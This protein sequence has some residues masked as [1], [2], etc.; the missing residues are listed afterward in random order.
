MHIKYILLL[1]LCIFKDAYLLASQNS[2]DPAPKSQTVTLTSLPDE[3]N[4]TSLSFLSNSDLCS[5][6]Q[7]NKQMNKIAKDKTL[8]KTRLV[9]ISPQNITEMANNPY[10]MTN[11][12]V[13]GYG[14]KGQVSCEPMFNFLSSKRSQI[15]GLDFSNARLLKEN[16]DTLVTILSDTTSITHLNMNNNMITD[17]RAKILA[18]A[19]KNKPLT[20]LSLNNCGMEN[21][22]SI[23]APEFPN[24]LITL[25]LNRNNINVQSADELAKVLR[26]NPNLTSLSLNDCKSGNVINLI[27]PA[28]PS[29]LV[30]L[31]FED[32]II[33]KEGSYLFVDALKRM[34][35]L[36]TLSLNDSEC[37]GTISLIAPELPTTLQTLNLNKC[38]L[39]KNDSLALVSAFGTMTKLSSLSLNGCD[40]NKTIK[41]IAPNLPDTLTSLSLNKNKISKENNYEL[42]K[43]LKTLVKLKKLDIAGNEMSVISLRN[44]KVAICQSYENLEYIGIDLTQA[45]EILQEDFSNSILRKFPMCEISL[46]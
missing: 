36:T 33:D 39:S 17:D 18:A 10:P 46:Y 41:Y 24:T 15:V 32:N 26:R 7:A 43:K 4:L 13:K 34:R 11:I 12:K 37:V 29:G 38:Q 14:L 27:I 28:L 9:E 25:N 21:G 1:T 3:L 20:Y 19:L 23:L 5:V 2:Q 16:F 40:L 6:A 35:G 42:I 8:W 45:W 30:T 44:I 22:V 31:N